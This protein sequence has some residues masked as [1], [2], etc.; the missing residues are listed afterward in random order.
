MKPMMPSAS[1]A[2]VIGS[3]KMPRT[4]VTK[5]IWRYIKRNKLQDRV[6]RTMI[7]ADEKLKKVF[8]GKRKVTMFEMTKLVSRHLKD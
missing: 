6:K 2:A 1:L 4:E 7:N 5:R 8:G 3:K